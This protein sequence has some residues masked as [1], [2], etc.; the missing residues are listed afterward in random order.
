MNLNRT[1]SSSH[2]RQRS[3]LKVMFSIVCVSV[4]GGPPLSMMHW[5]SPYTSQTCSSLFNLDPTI[6]YMVKEDKINTQISKSWVSCTCESIGDKVT[7][8][9]YMLWNSDKV[10]FRGVLC[11]CEWPRDKVQLRGVLLPV[12]ESVTMFVSIGCFV[13]VNGS[14]TKFVSA[15]C[16][17]HVN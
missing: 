11:K 7:G 3:C 15:V 1:F 14:V 17:V 4:H 13:N 5:T 12:N 10:R 9:L 8:C 6:C 16:F 2:V